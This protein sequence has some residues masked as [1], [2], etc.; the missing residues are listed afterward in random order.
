MSDRPAS[1][2]LPAVELPADAEARRLQSIAE[3]KGLEVFAPVELERVEGSDDL[4]VFTGSGRDHN[5]LWVQGARHDVEFRGREKVRV[6]YEGDPLTPRFLIP[7]TEHS[8]A[9]PRTLDEWQERQARKAAARERGR[10]EAEASVSGYGRS[11]SRSR[12][13]TWSGTA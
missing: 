9:Y 11:P 2:R 13:T 8:D 3:T 6:V 12:S 4:L 5:S 10:V 1:V 7:A